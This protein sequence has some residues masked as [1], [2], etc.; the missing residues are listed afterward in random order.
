MSDYK[1]FVEV[2]AKNMTY[3][4]TFDQMGGRQSP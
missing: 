2:I 3:T 4:T 1:V